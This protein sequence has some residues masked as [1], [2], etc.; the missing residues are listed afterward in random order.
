MHAR[1]QAQREANRLQDELDERDSRVAKLANQVELLEAELQAAVAE[2]EQATRK[3]GSRERRVVKLE[4]TLAE[5]RADSAASVVEP[6]EATQ[7]EP[8][9]EQ[10]APEAEATVDAQSPA[11]TEPEPEAAEQAAGFLYFV[12]RPGEGYELVEQ[13]G[14]APEVGDRVEVEDRTFDV[15]RHSRSPLP[16]DRRVCVYL[17][18]AGSD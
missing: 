7:T 6:E 10:Q 15:T 4:S 9:P 18:A 16:F 5:L 13:D 8:E 2:R 14:E 12:P 11:E 1:E 3:L 17:R